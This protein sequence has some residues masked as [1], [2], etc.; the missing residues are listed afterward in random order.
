MIS[1]T[2]CRILKAAYKRIIYTRFAL[3]FLAICFLHCLAQG[4]ILVFNV[5]LD[6]AATNLVSG[7]VQIA[8]VPRTNIVW[9]SRHDGQ[10]VLKLCSQIPH[11]VPYNPCIT[12]VG[13]T[14][15]SNVNWSAPGPFRRTEYLAA[16]PSFPLAIG[17]VDVVMK[18]SQNETG[19]VDGVFITDASGIEITFL[20]EQCTRVMLYPLQLLDNAKREDIVLLVS[21]FWLFGISLFG[22][23]AGSI[24]HLL[25]VSCMRILAVGW[26]GYTIWRTADIRM[27]FHNLLVE[28]SSPCH[29]DFFPT[30]FKTRF[31]YQIPELILACSG[32]VL[33]VFCGWHLVKIFKAHTFNRV[34]PPEAIIRMYR[35]H[36]A[37]RVFLHLSLFFVVAASGLWADQ[38]FNGAIAAISQHNVLYATLLLF[39]L[40]TLIPWLFLTSRAVR[41][42]H[43]VL[44]AIVLTVCFIYITGWSLMYFTQVY[45]WAWIQ[46]PFFACM[47]VSSLFTLI[48]CAVLGIISWLN[49]NKGFAQYLRAESALAET[50]FE[51]EMFANELGSESGHGHFMR[52]STPM[53]QRGEFSI[54][55]DTNWDFV[56]PKRPP[57]YLVDTQKDTKFRTLPR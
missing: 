44:M 48:M 46:W 34:G 49:F 32:C 25:A 53:S 37:L 23:L 31:S 39:T 30:Y 6:Q 7:I 33:T 29:Y 13:K 17:A 19:D 43:K 56:D 28:P 27:R 12:L 14:A 1:H 2:Q 45:R 41:H 16:T 4:L 10:D 36:L 42:E 20:D 38:L 24:P 50:D 22:V 55:V 57:I 8:E 54:S 9:H 52:A 3:P 35:Y 15:Q 11:T 18:A 21:Q 5:K 47:A 26:W 51:P 40:V